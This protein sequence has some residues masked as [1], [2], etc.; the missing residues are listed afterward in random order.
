MTHPL[1]RLTLISAGLLTGPAAHAASTL[2]EFFGLKTIATYETGNTETVGFVAGVAQAGLTPRSDV[3]NAET[4]DGFSSFGIYWKDG[5]SFDLLVRADANAL[6][7]TGISQATILLTGL[8]FK[9]G[10]STVD[11][12]SASFNE[13]DGDFLG[14]LFDPINNPTGAPRPGVSVVPVLESAGRWGFEITLNG[15]TAQ[16]VGDQAVLR[17]DVQ[18]APV[19]EPGTYGL[20]AL[21][22]VG[23][24]AWS[25]RQSAGKAGRA[26]K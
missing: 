23:V 14:Y 5:D 3:P 26:A 2:G 7:A 20:M 22:L 17:F 24:A 25:R 11:V 9:E 4:S 10:S 18:T 6:S 15:Y 8:L 12:L 16:L 1:L 13:N 21:G 19:P